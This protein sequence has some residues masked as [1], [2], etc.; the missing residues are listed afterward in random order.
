MFAV[1]MH[2]PGWAPVFLSWHRSQNAAERRA[3]KHRRAW[4]ARP[5]E[6]RFEVFY[7]IHQH[8]KLARFCVQSIITKRDA[9]HT[10]N[11]IEGYV[12]ED[13]QDGQPVTPRTFKPEDLLGPYKEQAELVEREAGEKAAHEAKE[14]ERERLAHVDRLALYTFVGQR[15]PK[16]ADDYDQ[17]FR[18]R[19]GGLN[20]DESGVKL[21]VAKVCALQA[22]E[23]DPGDPS[24]ELVAA[25]QAQWKR[26][27]KM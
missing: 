12:V 1:R 10:T 18:V 25:A 20:V 7:A 26:E 27:G 14:M 17:P 24:P 2:A 11:H 23:R 19:W 3:R 5:S 4:A 21:I 22:Q 13:K 6:R 15:P 16:D 9:K 8:G